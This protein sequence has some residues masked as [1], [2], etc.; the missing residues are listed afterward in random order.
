MVCA[1]VIVADSDEEATRLAA[2]IGLA[3]LHLRQGRPRALPSPETALAYPYTPDER[4]AVEAHT[5][6]YVVGGPA[7]ARAGL[8]RLLAATQA[9]EM[10]AITMVHDHGDRLRSYEL[11]S[12]IA[13]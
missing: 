5:A 8:D 10:M 1:S 2:P 4:A 9:D 11:L 3:M 12:Q 6:A 7:K 13:P